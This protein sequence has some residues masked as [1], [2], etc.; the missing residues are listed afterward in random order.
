MI[1]VITYMPEKQVTVIPLTIG[2][3]DVYFYKEKKISCLCPK[4]ENS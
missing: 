4:V 3:A 1:L 2:D